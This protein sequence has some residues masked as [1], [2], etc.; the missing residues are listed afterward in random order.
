MI[1]SRYFVNLS[2]CSFFFFFFLS[3]SHCDLPYTAQ[4]QKSIQNPDKNLRWNHL[5][6]QLMVFATT[7]WTQ[8][9]NWTYTRRSEDALDVFLTSYVRSIY[10]L[11]PGGYFFAKSSIL[12]IRLGSEYT[13]QVSFKKPFLISAL[14]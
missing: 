7:P 8:D 9:V 2:S 1:F 3:F 13:T 6:K 10:I 11:C 12:N 14:R 4:A 5:Q